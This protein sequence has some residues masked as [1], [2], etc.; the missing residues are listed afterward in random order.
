MNDVNRAISDINKN[1]GRQAGAG[2]AGAEQL[3][4]LPPAEADSAPYL[5]FLPWWFTA[6]CRQQL[7]NVPAPSPHPYE[8]S[9][10]PEPPGRLS[11]EQ[12]SA[13]LKNQLEYYFSR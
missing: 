4:A 2:G 6:E 5:P 7:L 13:R 11:P 9:S 3:S 8:P 12:L 10:T 1:A